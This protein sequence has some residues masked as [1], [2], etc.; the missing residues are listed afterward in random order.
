VHASAALLLALLAL[1]VAGCG[2]DDESSAETLPEPPELTVPGEPEPRAE[3]R[4]G[5][6]TTQQD[7]PPTETTPSEPQAAPA[8]RQSEP[9]EQ[10]EDSPEH[11]TPPPAGSPAERFE[12]FCEENPSSC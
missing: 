12:Q 4:S 8:P 9:R 1:T 3:D 5:E 7:A 2:G 11:D 6:P 10:P